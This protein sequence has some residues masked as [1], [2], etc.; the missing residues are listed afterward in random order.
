M[1]LARL[2]AVTPPEAPMARLLVLDEEAFARCVL[3]SRHTDSEATEIR[4][5]GRTLPRRGGTDMAPRVYA[6][7]ASLGGRTP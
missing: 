4:R 2:L 7:L 6:F 1:I 3:P 5:C